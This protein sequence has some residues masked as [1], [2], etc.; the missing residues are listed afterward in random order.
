MHIKASFWLIAGSCLLLTAAAVGWLGLPSWER[1]LAEQAAALC[2]G[3]DTGYPP[4]RVS[5]SGCQALLEGRVRQAETRD[6]L[7]ALVR[8]QLRL[9]PL[10]WNPVTGVTNRIEVAPYPSGWLLLAAAGPSARLIGCA[11]SETE[12]RDAGRL[13]QDRWRAGG[14]R[15]DADLQ[16]AP[17]RFDEATGL[18]P[19]LRLPAVPAQP[20]GDAAQLH[21]AR[22]GGTWLRL[23]LDAPDER[24]RTQAAAI[25]VSDADWQE[26]V[27]PVLDGLRRFQRNERARLAER[28]RQA[29]LPPPHVFLAARDRRLLVR[30]EVASL[31]HKREL[32]NALIAALPERRVLDDLR[33]N[34][35]RRNAAGFGPVPAELAALPSTGTFFAIGLPGQPWRPLARPDTGTAATPWTARLPKDLP[36]ELLAEDGRMAAQWLDG[37]TPGIPRLTAPPQPTFLTL[38]LLPGKVILAGQVADEAHRLQLVEAARRTYGPRAELL[39]DGLLARGSCA[40]VPEVEHTVR[41]FPPLPGPQAAAVL[42]FAHPGQA[43]R[44]RP[45]DAALLQPGALAKS[46]LLEIDFPVS[47]VEET[48][49]EAFDHLRQFWRSGPN[50]APR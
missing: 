18:E 5:F 39:T 4:V 34:P 6:H 36:A 21:L 22:L 8:D 14:G 35:Q 11:A 32:L 16:A 12:A 23:V 25:G 38:V 15:L 33:V 26:R 41:S 17:E 27:V 47:M 24:L 13:L 28:E 40:A 29:K 7:A 9:P 1:R 30:G 37:D 10:R 42:G 3:V 19:T 31:Q 48:L 2:A 45:A 20:G 44:S 46:G 50:P 49:A 43:W